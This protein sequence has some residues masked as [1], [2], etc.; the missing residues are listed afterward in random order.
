MGTHRRGAGRGDRGRARGLLAFYG[1]TPAYRPVLEVEGWGDLQPELN[2]LSKRGDIAC[3]DV[4]GDRRDG[5]DAGGPRHARGVRRRAR[6]G[7]S[8]TWPTGCAPTSRATTRGPSRSPAW[9]ARSPGEQR[10]AG[11]ADGSGGY[12]CR[13][14]S[15]SQASGSI[16][17]PPWGCTSRCRW[18]PVDVAGRADV[19]DQV[20]GLDAAG[21]GSTPNSLWWQ[22]QS[23]VPSSSLHDGLVAVGAVGRRWRR[24]A[25]ADGPDLGALGGR[26]VQAG[27]GAGPQAAGLRR[28]GRSGGS[29]TTGSTHGRGLGLELHAGTSAAVAGCAVAGAAC[30]RCRRSIAPAAGEDR[31]GRRAWAAM[32]SGARPSDGRADAERRRWSAG[33]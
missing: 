12:G 4:A 24:P 18:G 6:C 3:H 1:S 2:A 13:W 7:G 33:R 20:A 10:R 11:R 8:A 26:E 22:Y 32:S 15:G 28:S 5:R 14:C 29:P 30:A 31:R 19:P 23:T 21:P 16:G 9:P 17:S 25:R 27:V